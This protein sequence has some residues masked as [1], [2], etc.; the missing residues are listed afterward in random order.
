MDKEKLLGY[1]DR[2]YS[3]RRDMLARIPL[4]ADPDLLWEEVQASR[5]MRS[6]VLPL[7]G[8][9]GEPLRYVTTDKMKAASE[10]IVEVLCESEGD[11]DPYAGLPTVSTLEEIFFTSY[12]EGS[13]MT[14][15]EA[16][17]FL[18]GGQPPGNVSE[19]LIADNRAAGVYAGKNLHR[20]IDVRYITE[21]A[22]I[23][24]DGLEGGG[25][26]R[27]G[28]P[29]DF[30]L[31][32][33][34]RFVFPSPG[35]IPDRLPALCSFLASPNVHP[36][37]KAGVA[38]AY[39]LMLR[40]FSDGNDRLAR[41]LSYII[42]IRA[43][44]VFFSEVSV[45][46]LIARKNYAYCEAVKNILRAEN[47]GDLTY[48]LDCYL[49]LLSRAMDERRIRAERE[50][51]QT[52]KAESELARE[53]L[54][55]SNFFS[56]SRALCELCKCAGGDTVR[57]GI[58]RGVLLCLK[59]GL[60]DFTTDDIAKRGGLERREVNKTMTEFLSAGILKRGAD[61]RIK[62]AVYCLGSSPP[63][64]EGDYCPSVIK[65]IKRSR[66]SRLLLECLP[67]GTVTESDYA[68]IEGGGNFEKEMAAL[69]KERIVA[70]A[71]GGVYLIQRAFRSAVKDRDYVREKRAA[72][73]LYAQ[74]GDMPFTRTQAGEVLGM[75]R[76]S[77]GRILSCLEARGLA[78]IKRKNRLVHCRLLAN[79]AG[80]IF[81]EGEDESGVSLLES[82][83]TAMA[84]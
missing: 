73:M 11:F 9:N 47:G 75:T 33:G 67:A 19:Q 30:V 64:A 55:E 65:K 41:I 68:R 5:R 12:V 50:N 21:L 10:K 66:H 4:G 80:C 29:E 26:L 56:G 34:E 1:L 39:I 37:I 18:T 24:T 49:E 51:M 31:A 16:L 15:K 22:G 74:F 32:D 57:A 54:E 58:S 27:T 70:K 8:A 20:R 81:G 40:P 84:G 59:D 83:S 69:E 36:L 52:L 23:L 45:S 14:M 48:F 60:E 42:L 7:C 61:W 2:S 62:R 3:S 44:Y 76:Q 25:D 77:A 43:G 28:E 53:P 35:S 63:L 38:Q 17:D 82:G 72:E 6:T 13:Q 79:P 71:F 78:E 46:S